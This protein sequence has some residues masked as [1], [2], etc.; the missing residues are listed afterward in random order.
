MYTDAIHNNEIDL[1]N[2]RLTLLQLL[3]ICFATPLFLDYKT[4][5]NYCD[6]LLFLFSSKW[7]EKAKEIFFSVINMA[8]N[9]EFQGYV[10]SFV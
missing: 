2:N 8:Y 7:N 1:F 9:Y 4:N 6:P 3:L 5:L 10:H